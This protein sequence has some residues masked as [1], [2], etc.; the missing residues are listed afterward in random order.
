MTVVHL[1]IN[2][3]QPKCYE[4]VLNTYDILM[5]LI[6][7]IYLYMTSDSVYL[8]TKQVSTNCF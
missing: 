8:V 7:R 3:S 4:V 1:H 6:Y 5:Q 2:T